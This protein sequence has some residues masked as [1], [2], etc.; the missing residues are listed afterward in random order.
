MGSWGTVRLL[1]PETFRERAR[2]EGHESDVSALVFAPDGR[3][4][5]SA[6]PDTTAVLWDVTGRQKDGRL[7]AAPLSA[8][9]L[10]ARW[11]DLLTDDAARAYRAVWALVAAGAQTE[12]LLKE[13]LQPPKPVDEKRV[14]RLLADLDA[15]EFARRESASAELEKVGAGAEAGLRRLVDKPPSSEAYLRASRLLERLGDKFASPDRRRAVRAVE[16]LEQRNTPA[17]RELLESLTK[18][19][20]NGWLAQEARESLRRMAGRKE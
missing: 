19:E 18:G 9:E 17:A 10:R 3:S 2:F 15:D 20:P 14:A 1:E 12:T 13:K 5:A 7:P 11:E 6:S 4:L 16:V 8:E